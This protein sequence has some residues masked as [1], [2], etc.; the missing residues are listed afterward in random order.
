M[1]ES[2]DSR[3]KEIRSSVIISLAWR[4]AERCGAQ[5][6]LFIVSIILA[7]LLDPEVYGTIALVT[8]FTTILQTFVDGGLGNALIQKKDAD[9]LDFSSVFYFNILFCILL[10]VGMFFAAPIIARFYTDKELIAVIR[11]LSLTIVISGIKN[12]QQAYVSRTMQFKRFF[13]ATLGGTLGAA[14]VGIVMA[15]LG[16]GVWS[17]VAQHIFNTLVDTIVLWFTVRWR[18][19][20][21]FSF[22][23]LKELLSYGWKL[24][25]SSLL[26]NIYNE[27]CQLIIGKMYSSADLAQYNRGKQFPSIIIGNINSSI[28]SV[29]FPAMSNEQ[30]DI[31]R[32][33]NMTR[34]SIKISI[35]IMAPLMMG[36]AF[37][38]RTV[39][40]MLLT[41]KWLPCVPFVCVFCIIY[42]FQPIHTA[43][44][45]AIKALGRSDIFLKL[46]IL[47][48]IVGILALVITAPI[49]V[50]AMGYS[51]LFT[52]I[53]SQIINSWPN[54]KL[55]NYGYLEQLKDILPGIMLATAMGC[56]IYPLQL[57]E[58]PDIV[59]LFFQILLGSVIYITG[60][61]LFKLES[62]HYLWAIIKPIIKNIRKRKRK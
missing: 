23:R 33:R 34:Q 8:V 43:N 25:I 24:L 26:D 46:E 50:M 3:K 29:L 48:K 7:R 53:A 19:K 62:F 45:N 61:K 1:L 56:L 27:C 36:L 16:F 47:K 4:F 60:S 28:N 58:L 38:S 57:F 13:Y 22:S 41:E 32:V 52:S 12:V 14:I 40:R 49:S 55:L 31:V 5:G 10:Y 37:T 9:D 35:Y 21:L 6:V 42:M 51:L 18:P 11:V 39:V 17:L 54:R 44:L 30:N 59:T 2:E 15:Y 20:L